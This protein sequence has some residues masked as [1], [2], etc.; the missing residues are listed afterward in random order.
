MLLNGSTETSYFSLVLD[1]AKEESPMS[2][3]LYKSFVGAQSF[4]LGEKHLFNPPI[5]VLAEDHQTLQLAIEKEK[6]DKE[7]VDILPENYH[8]KVDL[9]MKMKKIYWTPLRKG[10]V[11]LFHSVGDNTLRFSSNLLPE[12][13]LMD[14]SVL[15]QNPS[16]K[17]EADENLFDIKW[18][19]EQY[20]LYLSLKVPLFK[21]EIKIH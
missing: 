14:F 16:L 18:Q 19:V 2:A 11:V 12:G 9:G 13:N 10:F 6:L 4:Y 17:L 8:P 15:K 21:G 7:I 5:I 20:F 3:K 1:V